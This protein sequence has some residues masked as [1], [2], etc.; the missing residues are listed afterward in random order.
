M[1]AGRPR[2]KCEKLSL[3]GWWYF[4]LGSGFLLLGFQRLLTGEKIWL[5][6]LRWVLSVGFFVLA[7]A[8]FHRQP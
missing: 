7:Y 6:L 2:K 8:E 5:V 4:C 3:L 1:S